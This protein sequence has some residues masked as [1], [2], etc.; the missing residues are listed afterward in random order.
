MIRNLLLLAAW[1]FAACAAINTARA[2]TFTATYAEL[3]RSPAGYAASWYNGAVTNDGKF[4][5]GM[6]HSHNSHG[7]NGLWVFDPKLQTHQSVS[8]NTGWLWKWETDANKHDVPKSGHWA[9]LDPVRDKALY[10]Y[11]GGPNV[12]ALTNRNNHQA[13]YMP[14]VDQFWVLAGTTF[15]QS[16]PY[17]GGRFD[18]KTKRWVYLSKPWGQK[19]A[20]DLA[21]FSAGMIAGTPAGWAAPNAATAVCMDLDTAVLFGGMNDAS[22][23]VRIIEPN[24]AGPE[25]YRWAMARAPIH[26]P[27]ENVRHNAACVGD[28]VYFISGQERWPNESKLRTPDPAPFWKFH[29]P[30]RTWT[31]LPGGPAGAYFTVMAYDA[32]ANALLVYGGS[33][34]NPQNRLW[35]YDLAAQQWHDLTGTV[36]NLPRA[37]MHTGGYIPGFGHVYKGGRRFRADGSEM[38]YTASAMM[39]KIALTRVATTPEPQPTPTPEPEPAPT[40]EPTPTPAPAPEPTPTPAPTPEPTPAPVP[41]PTPADVRAELTKASD[42]LTAAGVLL[43]RMES[44]ATPTPA[45]QPAPAPEPAPSPEPQPAPAPE[46][47]PAPQPQPEPAPTPAPEPAPVAAKIVWTKGQLWGLMNRPSNATKHM[48]FAE[49]PG[50]RVYTMG[51]D[52]GSGTVGAENSGRQEVY[53]FHPDSP[54][55]SW[56]MD[57]PYCGTPDSPVHWHTDEAGAVWDAKRGLI[58]KLAGTEYSTTVNDQCEAR[59]GSVKAKVIA[60]NPATGKWKVPEGFDQTRFGFVTNAV[61]DPDK[62][63]IVQIID[64]SARH[65]NLETGK[66][67]AYPLP[68]GPLRFNARTARLGRNVWWCNRAQVIESYNLDTHKLTS[69][70]VAPWPVPTEGWEMQM[71][72]PA[73]DKLLVIRPT[74]SPYTPRHAALFDPATKAWASIDPGEGWGNSGFM[75]SSGRVILMGGGI[76]GEAEAN[77]QVWVGTLSGR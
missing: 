12:V 42:A 41:V 77:K 67:T 74:S 65:L 64:E 28:T 73:G 34:S 45:P 62:D 32:A 40:P 14:G 49:G 2:D 16:S 6:G 25:R 63:E 60:F 24:P 70:S 44:A 57:A 68:K 15:Y 58:W 33:G 36:P 29:V 71:V 21:D 11:F 9:T 61:I 3:A 55:D 35:V 39:M 19:A 27:A 1:V 10:D 54:T 66:W 4:I 72:F 52:W 23:T 7:N 56:R 13:F 59:G 48:A 20:G 50:G 22:G 17:F 53:S 38:D 37:D 30:A 18:L 75:H 69:Y 31:R 43:I 47:A 26:V 8:P 46:P 5:Y 51:G 76:N